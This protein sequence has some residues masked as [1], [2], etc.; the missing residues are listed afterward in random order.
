GA[1]ILSSETPKTEHVCCIKACVCYRPDFGVEDS[2][3]PS[4]PQGN[5][6]SRESHIPFVPETDLVVCLLHKRKNISSR[7]SQNVQLHLAP[8]NAGKCTA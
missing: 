3:I 8:K 6:T 2:V 4:M 1:L 5:S 7:A